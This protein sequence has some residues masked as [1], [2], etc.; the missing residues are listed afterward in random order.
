MELVET[1]ND[2]QPTPLPTKPK[3]RPFVILGVVAVA[4]LAIIGGY[5]LLTAGHENTDDAQVSADLVPIG[6][7]VAG[8]VVKIAVKENQTV[9]KGELIAQ[10]DDADYAARAKQAEA[11]LATAQAQAQAADAQVQVVDANAKGGL[12]SARAAVS[13]SSVGVGSAEAQVMAARASLQR[14]ETDLRK[15]ELDLQRARE[16]K[17]AN[18]IPQ[19]RLD[20]A[21]MA[22]DAAA[23]SLAQAKAQLSVSEES[24]NMAVA[25]VSEARG[26]LS[27]S[28]PIEAQNAAARAQAD[29]A[30]ARVKSAEAQLDL[31]R[32]QLSYTRIVAPSD[33]VA[34]KLT[35]HE[36][37]LLAQGQPVIELVPTATYVIANFKE[38]Q[39]GK[40]KAGQ[41]AQ[42]KVDAYPG[43]DFEG[44]VESLSG[45]TGS[46]FSLLPADNASGNFVKVV[47]R[48]P[49]RISWQPPA[50]AAMRAG[51]SADVTVEVGR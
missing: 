4:V 29:L 44:T 37:Q 50:D 48:V 7:R 39:I 11:E 21:T 27:Q 9:K 3:R 6:T 23:A 47:Q 1:K 31:A 5:V 10:L 40:M 45:G 22:H 25:R 14:A 49:V 13:G 26:R 43:R 42:I 28:S 19:E 12:T 24:R 46:S 33:G 15:T 18:A 35:A 16:L 34:S 36:G 2:A 32:L 8:Q 30:H 17:A 41:K 38:T 51:L 20:N